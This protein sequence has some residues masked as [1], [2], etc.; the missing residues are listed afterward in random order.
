LCID[1]DLAIARLAI[2]IEVAGEGVRQAATSPS[3]D[4]QFVPKG[5]VTHIAIAP[6]GHHVNFKIAFSAGIAATSLLSSVTGVMVSQNYGARFSPT[7][8]QIHQLVDSFG[9]G[10]P[11]TVHGVQRGVVDLANAGYAGDLI[12]PGTHC[13]GASGEMATSA[14]VEA[15]VLAFS[16]GQHAEMLTCIEDLRYGLD[17]YA[18]NRDHP[19]LFVGQDVGWPDQ[20]S[21]QQYSAAEAFSHALKNLEATLG[22]KS[23]DVAQLDSAML[24]AYT[25]ALEF[26]STQ[27]W[28]IDRAAS[29]AGTVAGSLTALASFLALAGA[30]LARRRAGAPESADQTG[31]HRQLGGRVVAQVGCDVAKRQTQP[32]GAGHPTI[33]HP[34]TRTFACGAGSLRF[35]SGWEHQRRQA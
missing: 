26:R 30:F 10:V 14:T 1:G 31:L 29:G 23:V 33:G 12:F 3:E 25:R 9:R 20:V 11:L 22:S 5:A 17:A 7:G 32:T 24:Q 35:R 15:S 34:E 28:R 19:N 27:T 8:L 2:R 18:S 6:R 4:R 13:P 21:A 16:P